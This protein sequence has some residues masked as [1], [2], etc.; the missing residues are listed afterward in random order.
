MLH[1][2]AVQTAMLLCARHEQ[3]TGLMSAGLLQVFGKCA[4]EHLSR[5]EVQL[6]QHPAD[7]Q[8]VQ[9]ASNII[10]DAAKL[11]LHA[12]AIVH[13]SEPP[14]HQ[15]EVVKQ[16]AQNMLL[17]V[18]WVM[19]QQQALAQTLTPKPALVTELCYFFNDPESAQAAAN[20]AQHLQHMAQSVM[21]R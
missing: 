14:Q 4:A 7:A 18:F 17:V 10:A 8:A 19:D 12:I 21:G 3:P 6:Q 1:I 9:Q 13:A 15:V 5:C 2:V 11:L 20:V 16:C